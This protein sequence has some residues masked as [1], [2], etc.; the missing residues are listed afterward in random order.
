M[1]TKLIEV[2]TCID[3]LFETTQYKLK[4][5][6]LEANLNQRGYKFDPKD[7]IEILTNIKH[8]TPS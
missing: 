7:I 6:Y 4:K 1:D 5:R 8:K 3:N 2:V